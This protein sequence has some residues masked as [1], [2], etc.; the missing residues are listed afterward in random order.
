[1]L[2]YLLNYS[3][4]FSFILGNK[5]FFAIKGAFNFSYPVYLDNIENLY[6]WDIETKS[7]P[8]NCLQLFFVTN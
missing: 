5:R 7:P 8:E 4:Y 3:N 6:I 1:M 2:S